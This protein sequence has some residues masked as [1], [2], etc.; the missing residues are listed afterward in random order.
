MF[1]T[2]SCKRLSIIAVLIA[3]LAFPASASTVSFLLVE[4]GISEGG[5]NGQ[6]SRL[7]ESGLMSVFF[8]SGFIVT[9]S[10]ITQMQTRPAMDLSGEIGETFNEAIN[11]GADYFIVG[12]I[13]YNV[14]G[15]R[16]AAQ[17]VSVQIYDSNSRQLIY[18]QSFPA[19]TGRNENEE[20]ALAKSAG[21]LIISHIRGR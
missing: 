18:E 11:G 21:R 3:L 19:G 17:R 10:P 8:D 6:H 15:G 12:I 9:S 2:R 14:Y 5:V 4:T 13:E 20:F 16:V 7:W 1:H